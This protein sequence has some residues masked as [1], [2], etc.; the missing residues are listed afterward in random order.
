MPRTQGLKPSFTFAKG[1]I[2]EASPLNFPEDASIDEENFDILLDGTRRRRRGLDYETS[3]FS[4]TFAGDDLKYGRVNTRVWKNV[5][6]DPER[7]FS[8]V[9]VA[10]ILYFLDLTGSGTYHMDNLKSFT[11]DLDSYLSSGETDAQDARM[12]AASALGSLFVTSNRTDPIKIDYD[13]GTDTITVEQYT[14]QIRDFQGVDDGLAVDERPTTISDEHRYNLRNQGW[15]EEFRTFNNGAGSSSTVGDPIDRTNVEVG[16][17]PSNS[18]IIWFFRDDSADATAT[19]GAYN[20]FKLKQENTLGTGRA[21]RGHF[22]IDAVTGDRATP[23]GLAVDASPLSSPDTVTSF[24]GR[25]F[26]GAGDRVLF[27]QVL[28]NGDEYGYCYQNQDPTAEE[29][30]EIVA[31]DGGVIRIIGTGEITAVRSIEDKVFVFSENGIWSVTGTEDRGFAADSFDVRNI[32]TIGVSTPEQVQVVESTIMVFAKEGIYTLTPDQITGRYSA[33]NITDASIK[34][35]YDEIGAENLK[36]SLSRYSAVDRKVYLF[37]NTESTDD[38]APTEYRSRYDTVLVFDVALSAF[39]KYTFSAIEDSGGPFVYGAFISEGASGQVSTTEDVTDG[40]VTVTDSAVT[41][42]DTTV[43][44]RS[45]LPTIK[46]IL[47]QEDSADV[48]KF[49]VGCMDCGS[50]KDYSTFDGEGIEYSSFLETGYALDTQG[51]QFM[52]GAYVLCYFNRTETGYEDNGQGG[53]QFT[54]PSSCFMQGRW[55]WTGTGSAQRW[56]AEQQVY[57]LQ[58]PFITGGAG[59]DFDYDYRV[60]VTKNKLR[61]RGRTLSL[62]FRSDGVKDCHIIG[63]GILLG[64]NQL[65]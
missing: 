4:S 21:P 32:T 27:T 23:S 48:Y 5:G 54:N 63:W 62:Y 14:L 41:V 10:N 37:Y 16:L 20:P 19:I 26:Y 47:I 3:V 61:G 55:E 34:T 15:P 8:V 43:V 42:T 40:G 12:D 24:S 25:L 35:L 59:E 46:Y 9:Q 31:S 56:G 50:F 33:Q 60:V 39:Y 49:T 22:I 53:V 7:V 1:I 52:Q 6:G 17:Y 57:R 44:N 64:A 29:L 30:N 28:L 13:E 38:K 58:H 65:P 36:N 2:T 18:D 45:E 51:M 11:V